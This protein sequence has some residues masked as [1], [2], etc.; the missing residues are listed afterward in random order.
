M[1]ET[2][3]RF[4]KY[5]DCFAVYYAIQLGRC[6]LFSFAVL[7]LVL[8]L[9]RTL[10][11]NRIF[12]KGFSW[13][14]F[15]VVPFV[16]K[17]KLFYEMPWM[18]RLFWWWNSACMKFV[19]VRYGYLIGI[20]VTAIMIFYQRRRVRMVV[21]DMKSASLDGK[22]VRLADFS[23][24]PFTT[25]LFR[26]RIVLPEIIRETFSSEELRLICLHERTHA[27]LG[28]LWCYFLWDIGRSILWMNP[29]LTLCMGALQEDLEDICDAVTIQTSGRSAGEY[30]KLLLKSMSL[31]RTEKVS[32]G[33]AF[34]GTKEF[35][36]AKKRFKR[37]SRFE[38]YKKR[39]VFVVCIAGILLLLGLYCIIYQNSYP[40]YTESGEILI[41]SEENAFVE[42]KNP[43]A[44]ARAVQIEAD[45]VVVDV[46]AVREL[47]REQGIY[48]KSYYLLFGGYT[49]LPGIGGG[50][51]AVYVRDGGGEGKQMGDSFQRIPYHD[52]DTEFMTR[53]FQ[54]I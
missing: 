30:G 45:E 16:G 49:K 51:N 32:P 42:I 5:L 38:S 39:N 28:H 44:L 31:I 8:M 7:A 40:S 29:L 35:R 2:W 34:A 13:T 14:L 43:D 48:L 37:I 27:R 20:F 23:V 9:R 24:T 10:L 46:R 47:L 18:I 6:V 11:K 19:W 33:A 53:L 21:A 54:W 12:L 1:L 15:L 4:V 17:L 41:L 3:G 22:E 36:R 26:S 50:G 25:G 52:N